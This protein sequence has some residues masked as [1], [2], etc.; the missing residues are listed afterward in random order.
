VVVLTACNS[1]G[2]GDDTGTPEAPA[3]PLT[4]IEQ[5]SRFLAQATLGANMEE[6]ERV[7]ALGF[8]AWVGEQ[9]ALPT[10]SHLETMR[11]LQ[12]R[13]AV[14]N[15]PRAFSSPQFRRF[16]WWNEVMSAPDVLR[17][18]VALA[19]SEIFV[20][21]E[22]TDLLFIHPESV[23]SFYDLLLDH[24][25][26]S[27]EDLLLAVTLHPAMGVYLSHL[28]NDRSN[29]A[30]GR[31]PDENY[32]REVMQLFSIGLFELDDDGSQIL[33]PGA[34]PIPTYDN[35]DITEFAKIFTGLG[36]QG[37]LASFGGY[38]GDRTLPM[39]MY[40]NHHEPGPKM[41]L[42]GFSIPGGQTGM[43]DI[44]DAIG[45]LADHPNVGPFIAKRLIQRLVRSNPSP[46]YIER[47][48][49]IFSDDGN[50]T[51]GNL[52]A[53]VRG[54]LLDDEARRD[55]GESSDGFLREPFLRWVSLLRAF[56]ATSNSGEY[57]IDGAIP[58]FLIQQHPMASPSVF[59]FF[60]PDFSPN[61]P[62]KD[63]GLEAPE[64]QITNDSSVVWLENL[65]LAFLIAPPAFPADV[66]LF[67]PG[68]IA[69]ED[70]PMALDL[71]DET[72]LVDDID[73]L[74]DRLDL[75][76]TYGTLSDESRASIRTALEGADPP[77]RAILA[78]NLILSSP[79]Y[80]IV[81]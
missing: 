43:Q 74:I 65:A 66:D 67:A 14:P 29:V 30:L 31:F 27:Y 41:L 78:L 9:M 71:S 58:A 17:Q 42:N 21:S 62:I 81:D 47:I 73:G 34:E 40:E 59:N 8:E 50:G 5:S 75:L 77:V 37:P 54:I 22:L 15:D 13:Y 64:F 38:P 26:G 49:A 20:V 52:G 23:A 76:L 33:D 56:D 35:S 19:L 53:V 60:Q 72:A 2:G 48:S 11:R 68:S 32:A 39:V 24:A 46:A 16:A 61:G 36:L 70:I 80:A 18:R 1:G 69:E 25:F 12:N 63:A 44:E 4:S 55:P 79:D 57:L 3:E 6:I 28:N 10:T 7:E 51:R 45:H